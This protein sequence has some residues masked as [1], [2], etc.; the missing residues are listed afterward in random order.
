[1]LAK[2]LKQEHAFHVSGLGGGSPAKAGEDNAAEEAR[3][4]AGLRRRGS[5]ILFCVGSPRRPGRKGVT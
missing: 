1:M 2:P 5:L 4:T 3:E